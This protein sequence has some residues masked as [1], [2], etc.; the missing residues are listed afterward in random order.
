VAKVGGFL[1]ETDRFGIRSN[2][3]IET[4]VYCYCCKNDKP[5]GISF[6]MCAEDYEERVSICNDCIKLMHRWIQD[7]I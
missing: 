2:V 7:E 4:D 6:N 1:T 3:G 5:E